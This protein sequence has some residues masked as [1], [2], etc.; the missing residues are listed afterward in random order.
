MCIHNSMAKGGR[1]PGWYKPCG[2]AG[3]VGGQACRR[4][5]EVISICVSGLAPAD[6]RVI[7]VTG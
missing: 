7:F 1:T 5:T 6:R 2:A 3:G 4:Q